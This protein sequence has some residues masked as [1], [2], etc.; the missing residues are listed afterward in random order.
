[1]SF[2]LPFELM[3]NSWIT[4][5]CFLTFRF[6]QQQCVDSV[7]QIEEKT[8]LKPLV[9]RRVWFKSILAFARFAPTLINADQTFFFFSRFSRK[10]IWRNA[11]R[12][13]EKPKTWE[14]LLLWN[15]T[16]LKS[17][18]TPLFLSPS[19]KNPKFNFKRISSNNFFLLNQILEIFVEE[20]LEKEQP[21][22]LDSCRLYLQR[23]L[24]A[25]ILPN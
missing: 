17:W 23:G 18:S 9:F 4:L 6:D 12:S 1:M 11:S 20:V 3:S 22:W 24:R 2:S 5:K 25:P 14:Q 10:P 13:T 21:S 7:G 8:N 16:S 15:V 19:G